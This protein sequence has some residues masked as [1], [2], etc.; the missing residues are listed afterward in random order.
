MLWRGD[1]YFKL[2]FLANYV[3]FNL[4]YFIQLDY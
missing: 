2:E 3:I 4:F 1:T